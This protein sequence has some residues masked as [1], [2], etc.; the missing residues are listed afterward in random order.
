MAHGCAPTLLAL[1]NRPSLTTLA[2]SASL[3][4]PAEAVEIVDDPKLRDGMDEAWDPDR[5]ATHVAE[6][7]Q[8]RQ[9]R[10]VLTF[11]RYG[12]SRH[13]NHIAVAAGTRIA[14]RATQPKMPVWCLVTHALV[15]RFLGPLAIAY[16]LGSFRRLL[17]AATAMARGRSAAFPTIAKASSGV[18]VVAPSSAPAWRAMAQHRSQW[19]WFRVLYLI[20]SSYVWCN[21]F[22]EAA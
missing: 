21:T 2:C 1:R 14:A 18:C 15:V 22:R 11:D 17:A 16:Q 3:G 19:V 6:H 4:I 20:A 8:A 12:V 5:I 13:P 9:S 10:A 7:L